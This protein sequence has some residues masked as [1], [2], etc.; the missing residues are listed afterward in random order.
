MN[1]NIVEAN[2]MKYNNDINIIIKNMNIV[3]YI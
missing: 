3:L 1:I 2:M